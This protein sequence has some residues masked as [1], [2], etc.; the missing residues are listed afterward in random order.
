MLVRNAVINS[1]TSSTLCEM[2]I[3]EDSV[4]IEDFEPISVEESSPPVEDA[5]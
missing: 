5:A 1:N 2:F 4:S 3:T